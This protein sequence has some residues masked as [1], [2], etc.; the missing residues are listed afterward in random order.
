MTD[1]Y[2]ALPPD[3]R[4]GNIKRT[5]RIKWVCIAPRNHT[6]NQHY[7]VNAAALDTEE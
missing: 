4:C 2:R 5:A 1:N 3:K 6:P 7:M